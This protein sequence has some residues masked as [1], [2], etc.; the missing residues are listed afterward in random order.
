M[1]W[2]KDRE[3]GLGTLGVA[4]VLLGATCGL[5]GAALVAQH[6]GQAGADIGRSLMSLGIA[7]LISGAAAIVVKKV[8]EANANR[9]VWAGLL[10]DVVEVDSTL[11]IARRLILAHKTARTYSE[12]YA[13]ILRGKLTLRQVALDPLVVRAPDRASIQ[14]HLEAMMKWIDRL[15]LEYQS[16][17]LHAARQQRLDEAYFK[18]YE[19]STVAEDA[20]SAA[21]HVEHWGI[22]AVPGYYEPTRAWSEIEG[23]EQLANFLGPQFEKSDFFTAYKAVKPLLEKHAGMGRRAEG[24]EYDPEV[25]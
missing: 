15:G 6:F 24:H 2:V 12:Q 3:L 16:A 13:N 5:G 22:T 11:E 14:G 8:E 21:T 9:S 10:G 1:T 20:K 23:F 4:F 25:I 18:S 19:D 7:L 17:Y